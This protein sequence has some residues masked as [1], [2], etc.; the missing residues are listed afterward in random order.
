MANLSQYKI[1]LGDSVSF[2]LSSDLFTIKSDFQANV[3]SCLYLDDS[4]WTRVVRSYEL[5][6]LLKICT[7]MIVTSTSVK[8]LGIF[9]FWLHSF[10]GNFFFLLSL[11][12]LWGCKL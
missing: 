6:S 9:F 4:F 8:Y 3:G 11:L 5:N 1:A 7:A 12:I 10:P 2:G